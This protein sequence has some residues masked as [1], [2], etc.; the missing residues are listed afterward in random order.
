MRRRAKVDSNQEDVV[1]A[2]RARGYLVLSLASVGGGVPDLLVLEP[3]G[4]RLG[5]VEVKREKGKLTGDQEQFIAQGWPVTIIRS[6]E[7]ALKL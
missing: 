3:S 6:V 4:R 7:D 5:L 1:E 2:L